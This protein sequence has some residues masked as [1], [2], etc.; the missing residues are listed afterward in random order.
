MNRK[1]QIS[2]RKASL[3]DFEEICRLRSQLA[4]D[5]EDRYTTEFAS[6][7]PKADSTWIR[8]CLQD[9]QR[10]ILVAEDKNG[11]CAHAIIVIETVPKKAQK[12][13]TYRKKALLVH[14]YVAIKQR[15]E[16]IGTVLLDY[17]LKFLK[18]RNVEFVDLECHV[19]NTKADG[20]YKKLKFTH[21]YFKERFDLTKMSL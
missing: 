13:Y 9:R 17:T 19:K 3:K 1:P 20:L 10:V 5:P 21:E 8:K 15:H 12:Y 7:E 4:N 6:Y 18:Q 16:G 11:I 14:L 2:C